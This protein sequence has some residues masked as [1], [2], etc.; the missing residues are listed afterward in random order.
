MTEMVEKD[1]WSLTPTRAHILLYSD[2]ANVREQVKFAVG[3]EISGRKVRWL[4]AATYPAV[5]SA[6]D[7]RE[8]DLLILDGEA[9]K[10]GGMGIARQVRYEQYNCPPILLLVGRKQDAWLATWSEADGAV[11]HP[12]DAF[13]VRAAVEQFFATAA[14]DA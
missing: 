2:N 8:F 5:L 4:E 6:V 3:S 13:E 10:Y 7:D 14:A 9:A 12:L 11:A 1:E